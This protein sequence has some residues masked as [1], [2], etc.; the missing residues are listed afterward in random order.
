[1]QLIGQQQ[2]GQR[3]RLTTV[4]MKNRQ[5]KRIK[6]FFTFALGATLF[7]LA[8]CILI[9]GWT[10]V[11]LKHKNQ[12]KNENINSTREYTINPITGGAIATTGD[13]QPYRDYDPYLTNIF[14][15]T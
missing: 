12:I 11:Y 1:M 9:A 10:C 5:M 3:N 15:E 4:K 14:R 13:E 7:L 6:V 2:N 8:Q